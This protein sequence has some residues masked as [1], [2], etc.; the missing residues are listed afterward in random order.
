V[1]KNQGPLGALCG[2]KRVVPFLKRGKVPVLRK[3]NATTQDLR[4]LCAKV[5]TGFAQKQCDH[6]RPE[7]VF[8]FQIKGKTL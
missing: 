8:A 4:A 7:S 3:N 2:T 6:P 1:A 5:G